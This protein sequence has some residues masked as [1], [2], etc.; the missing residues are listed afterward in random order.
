[1]IPL[2]CNGKPG[3]SGRNRHNYRKEP[4]CDVC[5][6][7]AN[8][9]QNTRRQS[10]REP[11]PK[12]LMSDRESE[13]YTIKRYGRWFH[14]EQD[15]EFYVWRE[16]TRK[17][18]KRAGVEINSLEDIIEFSKKREKKKEEERAELKRKRENP[19]VP[20]P[21][22]VVRPRKKGVTDADKIAIIRK[23]IE[24]RTPITDFM[25]RTSQLVGANL[26]GKQ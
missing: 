23:M 10:Q 22:P 14:T 16:L 15:A 6:A 1:M 4:V 17:A 8:H 2:G 20:K 11:R 26:K 21:D 7:A 13:Y 3:P 25:I 19:R 9:Y 18:A 24:E 5:K 12:P